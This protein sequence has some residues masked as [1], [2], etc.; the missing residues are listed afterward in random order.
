MRT[1][2]T[3]KTTNN[4]NLIDK[5]F[6]SAQLS[7]AQLSSCLI[8]NYSKSY[9][10]KIIFF[11][12]SF[13]KSRESFTLARLK[14]NFE[15]I[16]RFFTAFDIICGNFIQ[17]IFCKK[18]LIKNYIFRSLRNGFLFNKKFIKIYLKGVIYD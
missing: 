11:L 13:C 5:F 7:S 4:D 2:K 6:S 12:F 15:I 10:Y 18:F 1:I 16:S 17:N 3:I 8:L 9:V 14:N